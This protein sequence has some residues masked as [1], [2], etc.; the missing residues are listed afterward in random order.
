MSEDDD[1]AG[2]PT[3]E[4]L[5]NAPWPSLVVVGAIL[6]S[7]A[8][9]V[10]IW[11]GGDAAALT[12]GF[13]PSDLD[14]GRWSTLVTVL[15]VH[16]AWAHAI[17]NALG[18]LAFGPPVARL[19]GSTARGVLAFFAFYLLCGAVSCLGYAALHLHDPQPVI[20]ASGAVSGLMGAAARLIGRGDRLWHVWSRPVISLTVGWA[21]ANLLLAVFGTIPFMPG[22]K[23]AW[24]A[25]IA[26]YVVG[27]VLIGPVA[28][29]L[30]RIASR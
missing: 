10:T 27:L 21:A 30:G 15:L 29:G 19:L 26:G 24:E 14:Q 18:A 13:A 1:N 6:A 20:G 23:V 22:A 25:H 28:R 7:Y 8:W 17:M 12:L 9:Q 2:A 3:R 5:L 16:G 4:P 11:G